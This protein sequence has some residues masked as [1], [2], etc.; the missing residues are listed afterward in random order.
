MI[1]S[2]GLEMERRK[3]GTGRMNDGDDDDELWFDLG[4]DVRR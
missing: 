2:V 4:D 1:N 3:W